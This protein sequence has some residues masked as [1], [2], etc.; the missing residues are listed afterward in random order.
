MSSKGAADTQ[1]QSNTVAAGTNDFVAAS[2][3]IASGAIS[4]FAGPWYVETQTLDI[5]YVRVPAEQSWNNT[6]NA[7]LSGLTTTHGGIQGTHIIYRYTAT[8]DAAVVYQNFNSSSVQQS[9]EFSLLATSGDPNGVTYG[10]LAASTM[11][12]MGSIVTTKPY[13]RRTPYTGASSQPVFSKTSTGAQFAIFKDITS[14]ATSGELYQTYDNTS[15]FTDLNFNSQST[16]PI[17]V[18]GNASLREEKVR[19]SHYI[20]NIPGVYATNKEFLPVN[21]FIDTVATMITNEQQYA[22]PLANGNTLANSFLPIGFPI[23]DEG[24]PEY[25]KNRHA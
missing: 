7:T 22:S 25:D 1:T 21:T 8:V 9:Q 14:S 13:I 5:D 20:Y 24:L 15:Y 18:I 16:M 23:L 11:G 3:N 19:L 6:C 10:S 17:N 2:G 12:P 4:A